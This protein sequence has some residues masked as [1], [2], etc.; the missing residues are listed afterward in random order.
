MHSENKAYI[1]LDCFF[2]APDNR[3]NIT[4]F[5]TNEKKILLHIRVALN[6][7]NYMSKW[8]QGQIYSRWIF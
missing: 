4:S 8:I 6:L 1:L 5:S 3:D 2:L 7:N